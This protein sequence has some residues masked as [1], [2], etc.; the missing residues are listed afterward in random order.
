M[1]ST[2]QTSGKGNIYHLQGDDFDITYSTGGFLDY[3]D[4]KKSLHFD[5]DQVK[6]LDSDIGQQV[7][8]TINHEVDTSNSFTLSYQTD[9]LTPPI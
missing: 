9:R 3:K 2:L 6:V 4:S 8:V 1:Q 7:H 5:G